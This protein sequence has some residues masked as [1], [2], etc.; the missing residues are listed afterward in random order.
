MAFVLRSAQPV[1]DALRNSSLAIQVYA[2]CAGNLIL[3]FYFMA[4]LSTLLQVLRQRDSSSLV[5]A[6]S[7]MN[8][9]NGLL[10]ASYGIFALGDPLVWAPNAFGATLGIVQTVLKLTIP[11]KENQYASP[12]HCCASECSSDRSSGMFGGAGYNHQVQ[13]RPPMQD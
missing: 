5:L 4:P 13:G 11:S 8:T 10:W 1:E 2:L 9:L 3:V 7:V 6:L 12:T